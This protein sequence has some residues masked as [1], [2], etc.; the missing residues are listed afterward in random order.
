MFSADADLFFEPPGNHRPP[1]NR[2][3]L[4]HLLRRDV[5]Q[6]LGNDPTSGDRTDCA[7]WLAAMG[8]LAGIDLLAKYYAG[9]D[10]SK[11][12]V[13]G[14][15]YR[16]YVNTYFQPIGPDDAET[17]W[18]FRNALIHSFGLF[19]ESKAK[20]YHFGMSMRR[21]ALITS[22]AHDRYTVDVHVLHEKFEQSVLRFQADVAAE[23]RFQENFA[24][25]FPRYGFT[26]YG[27]G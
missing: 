27:G 9:S 5:I 7:L 3:G 17:L 20:T 10:E 25:M 14:R 8:I 23:T 12:G 22:R 16:D 4:L 18:Q 21:N 2:Y 26:A 19:S 6:C 15:R 11:G 24:K 13:I 1:P